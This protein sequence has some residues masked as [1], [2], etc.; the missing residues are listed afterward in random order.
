MKQYACHQ[1]IETTIECVILPTSIQSGGWIL[2]FLLCFKKIA[3]HRGTSVGR[4]ALNGPIS[5][6]KQVILTFQ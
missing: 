5:P 4:D 2:H 1:K 3:T 6:Y